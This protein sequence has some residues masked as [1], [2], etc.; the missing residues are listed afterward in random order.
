MRRR[1]ALIALGMVTGWLVLATPATAG[2]A[3]RIGATF[4]LMAGDFVKAAAPLEGV[5]VSTEGDRLYIDVGQTAGAQAGQE[6]TVFR[7]GEPFRHPFTGKV[8]GRYEEMLGYA[9][10]RIVEK[11]F[12]QALF[13]PL[14]DRPRPQEE[15]GVRISRGRIRIAITPLLDLT[16]SKADVRRVPYLLGSTL[17]RSKRFQV[18]DPLTVSDVF[19]GGGLSVGEVLA[20]PERAIRVAKNLDVTGWLVP[21]LLERHGEIYLDAT[22]V[23]AIT[24]TALFSRRRPLLSSSVA[25]EQ[26]FPWEPR[27]ED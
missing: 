20:R 7:K 1:A 2:L 18:V 9:Q 26:R 27:P 24:G 22:W 6:L 17:E 16:N 8:L 19:A 15:D 14:P 25:E 5:V 10:I 13:I 11:E 23:S 12:S 21:V 4:V 3:D